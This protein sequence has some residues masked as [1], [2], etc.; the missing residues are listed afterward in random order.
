MNR[1]FIEKMK[2]RPGYEV[3]LQFFSVQLNR[4]QICD[5][6]IDQWAGL[7]SLITQI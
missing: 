6:E 5:L 2:N 3:I 7:V 4:G 1:D